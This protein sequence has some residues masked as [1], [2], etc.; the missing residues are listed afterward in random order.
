MIRYLANRVADTMQ[1]RYDYDGSY[2]R[3]VAQVSGGGALRLGVLLPLLSGYRAGLPVDLWAGA[4]VAST[5]EGDCGPCLQLVV[6]MALEQGADAAALR[7]ILRGRPADAGV[8]GLGYR[9]ALAAIGGGPDL[10]PLRGEIGAR[11]G[12][13]ALVSLAIV[14]ATG[15]AW[16]VI[17]RGLGHGQA[18]RAVSVAGEDVDAGAAGVS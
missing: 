13:R 4:A 6:D 7:A 15:R 16:P 2:L 8:T 18:C 11:Y 5:R 10:E 3:E 1:R 17:K 9:F 12:E 14:S